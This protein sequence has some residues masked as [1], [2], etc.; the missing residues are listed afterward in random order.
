MSALVEAAKE[1]SDF[2]AGQGWK[3]CLIGGLTVQVWGEL[4]TTLDVDFILLTGWGFDD[5]FIDPLL[6]AFEPRITDAK[7]FALQNRVLL[8]YASNGKGVDVSLGALPF[9]ES[10]VARSTSS[11]LEPGYYLPVCSAEDLFVMK[12]FA[13]RPHDWKDIEGIAAR[14]QGLDQLYILEHLKYLCELKGEPEIIDRA[15]QILERHQ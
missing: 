9:E 11:E 6:E 8:L 12:A 2:M 10:V 13:S 14:Q 5:S 4:R 15:R 1:L 3:H 7:Q